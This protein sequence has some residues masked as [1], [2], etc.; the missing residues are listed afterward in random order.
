VR[1]NE[2]RV[3]AE[4][5]DV[6]SGQLLW[7]HD[8]NG[9]FLIDGRLLDLFTIQDSIADQIV[10]Q[11]LPQLA[12]AERAVVARGVR[13]TSPRSYELYLE[14]RRAT[15]SVTPA[16]VSR[17]IALFQ[18]AL[19]GDSNYADAW[20]GLADAY[21]FFAQV[22]GI[23]PAEVSSRWRRA[24]ERAIEL[25]SLNGYAYAMRGQ[26]RALYDWDWERARRDYQLGLALSPSS[27]EAN[28]YYGQFHL[29]MAQWDSALVHI[30]RTVAL[31]PLNAFYRANLAGA[32]MGLRM[33]DS[34]EV[35]V[36][37]SL[38]IDSTQWVGLFILTLARQQAGLRQQAASAAARMHAIVGDSQPLA[39]AWLANYYG[40]SERRDDARRV[41]A[42][43]EALA[44]T[45]H[46]QA[47]YLGAA[48][49]AAGDRAGALDAIETAVKNH[50]LDL[51]PD[52][53]ILGPYL[54]LAGEPRFERARQQ[55][56]GPLARPEVGGSKAV[57]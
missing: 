37:R 8:F 34:V 52:L 56:F 17:A 35:E 44:R 3:T 41:L 15:Y 39:L 28:L 25:D 20:V 43:L 31:E 54:S 7:R 12:P 36:G 24:A 50:D 26:I 27:P 6:G 33:L 14:G 29:V 1:G 21:S 40:R 23:A 53:G 30:K 11:L 5:I 47:T 18:E 49:L 19:S 55:V 22:G 38:A 57:R 10:A 16:G 45:Q 2:F 13:T 51:P 46:I 4:L 32:Y 9:E 42:Q 48:R